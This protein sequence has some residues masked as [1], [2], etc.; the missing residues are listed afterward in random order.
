MPNAED[1]CGG[2]LIPPEHGDAPGGALPGCRQFADANGYSWTYN[3][4]N[5]NSVPA[6]CSLYGNTP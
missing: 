2:G 4:W 1:M 6:D 5:T 3:S